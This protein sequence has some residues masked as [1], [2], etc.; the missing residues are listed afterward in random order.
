MPVQRERSAHLLMLSAR[1]EAALGELADR[2][3]GVLAG[4]SAPALADMAYTAHRGRARFARRLAVV[5]SDAVQAASALRLYR[6]EGAGPGV[7]AGTASEGRAP[8]GFLFTGQGSQYV[9]MAR[10]LYETE[11]VVRDVLDRCAAALCG[12]LDVPLLDVVLGRHARAEELL[13]AT[14]FTQ[15]A[16]Y[17][18][19]CALAQ[20][21]AE[22]GV[23]PQAVLGHSVGE[24]AAAYTAGVVTLEDG[25]VLAARRGG[26]MQALPPGGAMAAVLGDPRWVEAEAARCPEVL[27]VSA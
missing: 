21:W 27:A 11:P 20:L 16:L 7:V 15:P 2:Y 6:A 10:E 3:A 13:D 24:L 25:A 8:I 18:V 4:D 5:A 22:L 12:V 26:L 23:R 19:S 14:A 9:G 1:S 17:S